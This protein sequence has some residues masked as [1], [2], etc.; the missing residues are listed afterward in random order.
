[1]DAPVIFE[2]RTYRDFDDHER[3]KTFR[4]VIETS[5]L[6]VKAHSNLEKETKELV[7]KGRAQVEWAIG[8]RR[9]FLTSLVPVEED[10][11][12][13]PV[14]LSMIRAGKKAGTGPMAAVAG[15]IAEFVGRELCRLS[16]EVIVENGGDIFL[17]VQAPVVVGLFAGKSP[18]SGRIG[19]KVDATAIPLGI[20]TSSAKVGPSLSLGVADAATIISRDVALADAVATGLGNRVHKHSDLKAAVEWA[21]G[22]PGVDAALA[23]LGD[24]IAALGE[25]ELV[26][27]PE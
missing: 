1:M 17:H 26:S 4:V 23:I 12:D 18:F 11:S 25:L 21:L 20:C 15:A 14:A 27:I 3:F 8:K 22:V 6:Y 16:P 24:K 10:P 9:E 7:T 13:G 5:D 2:P 19:L